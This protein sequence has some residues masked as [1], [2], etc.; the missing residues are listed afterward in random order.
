MKLKDNYHREGEKVE[1]TI[2]NTN[3]HHLRREE[4]IN[5]QKK[6]DERSWINWPQGIR[7]ECKWSPNDIKINE[8]TRQVSMIG[9]K[10]MLAKIVS[11]RSNTL[12]LVVTVKQLS[13]EG[14]M[15]WGYE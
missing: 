13:R 6:N 15:Q 7:D 12:V 1:I 5:K 11:M 14:P 3:N 10:A 9:N 2:P 8:G 4:V